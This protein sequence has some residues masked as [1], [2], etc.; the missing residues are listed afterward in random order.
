[1][2]GGV[3]SSGVTRRNVSL[4]DLTPAPT[5]TPAPVTPGPSFL[6]QA[7]KIVIHVGLSFILFTG[8][9]FASEDWDFAVVQKE[10]CSSGSQLDMNLCLEREEVIV[11]A[12][13]AEK[14]MRLQ[15]MLQR[16]QDA[17]IAQ[18]TWLKFKE[19]ECLFAT[20]GLEKGQSAYQFALHACNIDLAEKRIR[21]MDAHIDAECNGCPPRRSNNSK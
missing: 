2:R 17:A 14:V 21:D 19:Q 16:P 1:M 4:Q 11:Y 9:A 15:R 12:R 3:A 13:L 5:L 20:S 6:R 8:I 7:A 18:K 10:K